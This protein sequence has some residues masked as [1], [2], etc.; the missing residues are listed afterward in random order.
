[1]KESPVILILEDNRIDADL[2]KRELTRNDPTITCHWVGSKK[3]YLAFLEQEAPVDCVISDYS[4]PSYNAVEA[5]HDLRRFYPLIP[6]IIVS[7]TLGDERAVEIVRMG[8]FDFVLKD[9]IKRLSIAIENALSESREKKAKLAAQLQLQET[10]KELEKSNQELAQFAFVASHDMKT[11]ISN[12]VRL[13]ELL[14]EMGG[15]QAHCEELF[16][17]TKQSVKQMDRTIRK[18]NEVIALKQDYNTIEKSHLHIE[19]EF[20]EVFS[21]FELKIEEIQAVIETDFSACPHIY[22]GK[23]HLQSVFQ[24]LLSNAIKYRRPD[25]L[26]HVQVK[27]EV[28]DD[29]ILLSFSDN[30]EGI[31]LEKYRP[32]VFGL[33]QRFNLSKGGMGV[34]LHIV[35]SIVEQTGG[36]IEIRSEVGQG[37]CFELYFSTV[38]IPQDSQQENVSI[39]V[40]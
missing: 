26:L 19:V 37:T 10:V 33:F 1:M 27:T 16:D 7:G 39:P 20:L 3:A 28:K 8:A 4:L 38:T 34:G 17:K 9:S 14:E 2:L 36:Y 31:D 25:H 13:V 30:G 22:M 35:K 15:I 29:H 21:H 23:I 12:L 5:L 18:L 11:P 24:N 6:L 32:K 40:I